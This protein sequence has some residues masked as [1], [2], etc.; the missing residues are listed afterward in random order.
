MSDPTETVPAA[1][2]KKEEGNQAFGAKNFE[3]AV[4]LYSQ[5][6][7]LDPKNHI[8]FSNRSACYVSLSQWDKAAAD[9]KECLKL[10]PTFLKAYYRLALSLSEAGD[11]DAAHSA[12]KQGLSVDPD[13]S[14]LLKQ[15]R[16]IN[17]KKKD[18]A[19]K[20][21]ADSALSM[22]GSAGVNSAD[23]EMIDLQQ[24]FRTSARDYNI[25]KS[26]IEKCQREHKIN[27]ITKD[28][29]DKLPLSESDSKMYRGIGKMFL[30]ASRTEVNEYLQ[31][32]IGLVKKKEWEYQAKL[33]YLE[34]RLKSQ[35]QN[36][37]E[38]SMSSQSVTA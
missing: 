18:A 13:N 34:K 11:L 21:N 16:I 8:Y 20:S 3:E 4:S 5:A 33:E 27:E 7:K 23:S 38:L 24:Q 1:E 14:Q 6:I 28:E 37:E 26:N 9:A 2:A 35:K 25:C 29:L 17:G 12:A 36:I 30:M 31:D 19:K 22:V 32:E 10:N 15:L